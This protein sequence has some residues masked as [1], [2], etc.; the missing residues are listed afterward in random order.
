MPLEEIEMEAWKQQLYYEMAYTNE[1]Y[2]HGIIGQK[3]GV[4]RYQ[5][6]DGT[7]T[8]IGKKRYSD[9]GSERTVKKLNKFLET[10][11][12]YGHNQTW[13]QRKDIQRLYE[14]YDKSVEKDLKNLLKK[15]TD[16]ANEMFNK[17]NSGRAFMASLMK[18]NF[19]NMAL[20]YAAKNAN[21]K[22][23]EDFT[24]NFTRDKKTGTLAVTV[25]GVRSD[26]IY[27]P[28]A[29]NRKGAK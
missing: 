4:R 27:A 19:A 7:L 9:D 21:I 29:I 25:N 10:D 11:A 18:P 26:Y 17:V 14:K 22:E 16:S 8:E 20:T 28:N 24:Y 23:G 15:N 3:W 1:L 2:H 12:R 6:E 5:N 13:H